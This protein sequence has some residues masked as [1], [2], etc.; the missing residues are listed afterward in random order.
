[1]ASDGE[2]RIRGG[3]WRGLR[4]ASR[5]RSLPD[6]PGPQLR[7]APAGWVHPGRGRL[8]GRVG[9][10]EEGHSQP[11]GSLVGR[12]S[13]QKGRNNASDAILP[14]QAPPPRRVSRGIG[15][16]PS[17]PWRAEARKSPAPQPR[18][19]GGVLRSENR[20]YSQVL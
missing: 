19:V 20:I 8:G 11:L 2:P 16:R 17:A 9:L 18:C 3:G 4:D 1:M 6:E 12:S 7:P 5:R 10:R 14:S 13:L 15:G